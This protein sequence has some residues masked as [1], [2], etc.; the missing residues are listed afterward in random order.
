[1]SDEMQKLALE[2]TGIHTFGYKAMLHQ[3]DPV[4]DML[5]SRQQVGKDVQGDISH[6]HTQKPSPK[7][8]LRPRFPMITA[9]HRLID[10]CHAGINLEVSHIIERGH[11]ARERDVMHRK[12][13]EH[14]VQ[15]RA[16]RKEARE[17]RD[18]FIEGCREKVLLRREQEQVELQDTLL[19]LKARQNQEIQLVKERYAL[20]L[21]RKKLQREEQAK[22]DDLCCRHISLCKVIASQ[23]TR[24]WRNI[25][26]QER[27]SLTT[28]IRA[29]AAR[30][31][32]RV[33][34]YF[35]HRYRPR[36]GGMILFMQCSCFQ[37][38]CYCLH[39][40]ILL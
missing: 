14:V 32:K 33:Q 29:H 2:M 19:R 23:S 28:S 31:K 38:L 3:A 21:E 5:L 27:Q 20:F 4:T 8:P 10:H 25:M 1:M 11:R 15:A 12:R 18:V 34:K 26:L 6:F 36:S 9:E 40:F 16:R 35:E 13:A 17:H 7:K 24:E 39:C 37:K 22:V 30:Q